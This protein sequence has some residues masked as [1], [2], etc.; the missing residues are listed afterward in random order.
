MRVGFVFFTVIA[1][2]IISLILGS[3]TVRWSMAGGLALIAVPLWISIRREYI[4]S[5]IAHAA[6]FIRD[7]R[8]SS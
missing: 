1:S 2:A 8:E 4:S 3:E 6:R 7:R 5:G